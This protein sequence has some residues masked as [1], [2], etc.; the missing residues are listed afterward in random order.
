MRGSADSRSIELLIVGGEADPNTRRVADQ[1]AIR[2]IDFVIA[3]TDTPAVAQIQWDIANPIIRLGSDVLCPQAI[4]LRHNVFG[5]TGAIQTESTAV[6]SYAHTVVREFAHAWPEIRILNRRV[7]GQTNSKSANL[8]LAR[9]LGFCVPHTLVTT[10]Q[11]QLPEEVDQATLIA[12][13][14]LGGA[15]TQTAADFVAA[16]AASAQPLPPQFVQHR[17]DGH[18]VRVFVIGG[19]TFAFHIDS[20]LLDYR[21]ERSNVVHAIAT[22]PGLEQPCIEM[23]DAIGFDYCAF[24]FRGTQAFDEMHFLEVNSF[25]MFVRFDMECENR[26]V[27]KMLSVLLNRLITETHS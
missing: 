4:F 6:A 14:L 1:A 26:L 21:D 13:P 10:S 25:P 8:A 3:D 9:R 2:G 11:T 7:L 19:E 17:L 12:K 27:D 24:D 18:N 16:D 15:H 5:P 20:D 23:A 22:P